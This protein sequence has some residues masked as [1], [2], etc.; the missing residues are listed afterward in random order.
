MYTLGKINEEWA[1]YNFGKTVCILTALDYLMTQDMID[2]LNAKDTEQRHA[3][4]RTQKFIK[5]DNNNER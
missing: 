3:G 4:I 2:R 1:I 5:G